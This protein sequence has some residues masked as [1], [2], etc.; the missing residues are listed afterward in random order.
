[1]NRPDISVMPFTGV[2]KKL[3]VANLAI[4]IIGVIIIGNFVFHDD[5]ISQWF[6]FVPARFF[7]EFWLWQPFTYMFLHA[8][9]VSH[10]LINMLMLWWAGAELETYWGRRYFLFYY[11]ICGIGAALIYCAGVFAYYL[12]TNKTGPLS[13]PMIGASGAIYGLLFAYG[14]LFGERVVLFLML[15]PMKVKYMVMIMGGIS[16]MNLMSQGLSGQVA[17]LAHLGGIIVG[18]FII[19]LGPRIRDLMVRRQT[20]SHGRKLKLVVDNDRRDGSGGNGP[21]YWN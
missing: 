21:R 3:V 20:R 2:V 13:E 9:N 4:W 6:G 10:V 14:V 1:M 15:F 16:L 19:K 17:D 5:R 18:W 8:N 12:F 11:M 7:T